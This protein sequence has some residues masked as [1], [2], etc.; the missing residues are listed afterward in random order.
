MFLKIYDKKFKILDDVTMWSKVKDIPKRNIPANIYKIKKILDDIK[1]L[2]SGI[3]DIF[4]S[5]EKVSIH[6]HSVKEI[7]H[8]FQKILK[9]K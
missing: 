3:D 6:A 2:L 7:I 1:Y 4:N 8:M 9:R 5:L